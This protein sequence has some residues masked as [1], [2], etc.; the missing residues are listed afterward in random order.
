MLSK[1]LRRIA[2]LTCAVIGLSTSGALADIGNVYT[3]TN[4]T[5]GNRINQYLRLP[6]GALFSIGSVAT[7][8]AG[9]GA[10]L[11]N[12]GGVSI[13][14]N[15]RWLLAVNA[16]SNSVSVFRVGFLGLLW[17]TDTEPSG[18]DRPVSVTIHDDLV[19]VLNATGAG[20]ISGFRLTDFGN[21][22]PIA[23]STRP[24]SGAASTGAA[25][26]QFSPDGEMLV[27][28]EKDT[29]LIDTYHVGSS[30]MAQGPLAQTSAGMTPFGFDF[31]H[32][33]RLIVSEAFGGAPGASAVSS[34]DL[35]NNGMLQ[36]ITASAATT[37][38]AACWIKD[39]DNGR[40]AYT[41]NTGSGNI[42]GYFIHPASGALTLLHAD[43]ITADTGPGSAPIDLALS[44]HSRFLFV[45]NSGAGQ[46][47]G[48][49]VNEGNGSLTHVS[50]VSG[51][52]AGTNGLASR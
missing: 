1:H 20:S 51:L 10:G 38:T 3:A 13:S 23:G 44:R 37:L 49:R 24:L 17:R 16:G 47:M 31:A 46:I 28:T 19:Y 41:T 32:N 22:Q 21:L 42:S 25:Q 36:T 29:S 33:D 15:G 35:F 7:G 6:N 48:F 34:Y 26:I 12:Q 4:S 8:G 14:D 40:I 2:V 43:G 39:T 30:G 11:G 9:T 27:V 18:G 45:L 5:Q 50:T 52:P